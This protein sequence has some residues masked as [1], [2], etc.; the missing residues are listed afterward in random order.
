MRLSRTRIPPTRTPTTTDLAPGADTGQ[1]LVERLL[2][3]KELLATL[4]GAPAS[5]STGKRRRDI[6]VG[7]GPQT[8]RNLAGGA[9][10]RNVPQRA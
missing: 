4:A 9:S 3:I 1:R 5:A 7:D 10:D 6:A 8:L 2:T